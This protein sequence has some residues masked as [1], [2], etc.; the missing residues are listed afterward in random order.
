MKKTFKWMTMALVAIVMS[1]GFA[2]CSS[3]DD[4]NN[5]GGSGNGNYALSIDL[6]YSEDLLSLMDI[7]V[8]YTDANGQN[9]TEAVTSTTF[10]KQIVYPSKPSVIKYTVYRTRKSNVPD[11]DKFD[12]TTAEKIW[13]VLIKNGE[14]YIVD[15]NFGKTEISTTV[16]KDLLDTFFE[17]KKLTTPLSGEYRP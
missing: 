1:V 10:K 15:G 8:T 17:I 6:S 9:K 5:G 4:N 12:I 13:P 3:D 11:K 2:A 16:K 14:S 7:T